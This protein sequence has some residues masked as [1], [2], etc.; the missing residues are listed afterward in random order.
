MEAISCATSSSAAASCARWQA[1]S[2]PLWDAVSAI[3][4]R[5]AAETSLQAVTSSVQEAD[6]WGQETGVH[7]IVCIPVCIPGSTYVHCIGVHC[8]VRQ[9][10]TALHDR[11]CLSSSASASSTCGLSAI[12]S[13]CA[14]ECSVALADSHR[15]LRCCPS[16]GLCL[17][18]RPDSPCQFLRVAQLML[19]MRRNT[20]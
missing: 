4:Q 9:V 17:P 3:T 18:C 1:S 14:S 16:Q 10:C 13:T 19:R 12:S 15:L 8:I 20:S 11:G 5:A 7:S 6:T 2:Q